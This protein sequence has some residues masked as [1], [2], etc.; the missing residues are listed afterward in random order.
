MPFQVQRTRAR[1]GGLQETNDNYWRYRVLFN[2]VVAHSAYFR[3]AGE[4]SPHVARRVCWHVEPVVVGRG[5]VV[6]S[7]LKNIIVKLPCCGGVAA[8]AG[9]CT[10]RAYSYHKLPGRW[11]TVYL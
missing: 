5:L 4:V 3:L 7:I 8:W 11:D 2:D 6:Y 10:I 1:V 9:Q